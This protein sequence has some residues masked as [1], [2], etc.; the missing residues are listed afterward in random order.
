LNQVLLAASIPLAFPFIMFAAV[1]TGALLLSRSQQ[2]LKLTTEQRTAVGLAAFCGA[3]IGAKAPFLLADWE[4]FRS[5]SAWFSDGKTIL[6][7]MVCAYFSVE[8]AKWALHIRVKTG[9]SFAVPV[10]ASVS[11]GR[12]ACLA[13]GC[14]YG[15]PTN[16]P[17]ALRCATTDDL[18]RHP[19][20][21]YE[22]LFH[23]SMALI[24]WALQSRGIWKG[25]LIKFYIITYLVYRF[26]TEFIR[27]EKH[28][29]GELT[30]YQW[31][32]LAMLP[33]F[34]CLWWKDASA[35][36][37]EHEDAARV[38]RSRST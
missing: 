20:Q 28:Y 1:A 13:A 5:G 25:Q 15:T 35:R 23:A 24:C 18:L 10:A 19:T 33:V 4:G 8:F 27:P 16:V 36:R 12:L 38:E 22:S 3:M 7:G 21:I 34:A 26:T 31:F 6:C 11:I 2:G 37:L 9:D 14:C 32:S 29:L 17:W 30:A